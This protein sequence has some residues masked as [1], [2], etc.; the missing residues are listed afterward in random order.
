[1]KKLEYL[2]IDGLVINKDT[3]FQMYEGFPRTDSK[4]SSGNFSKRN[5]DDLVS[6]F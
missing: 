6:A 1:M 4:L 5:K 3:P 2:D